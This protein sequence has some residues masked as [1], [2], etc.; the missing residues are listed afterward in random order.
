M[1]RRGGWAIPAFCRLSSDDL[2][3]AE[4][5]IELFER[6][7]GK[8]VGELEDSLRDFESQMES[9][10][11]HYKLVRGLVHILRATL[12]V[13]KPLTA[14]EPKRARRVVYEV[15]SRRGYALD[16]VQRDAIL[17]EAASKLG[18]SV[19]ELWKAYEAAYEEA[20]VVEGFD[21]PEPV[22]LLRRYNLSLAQTALF[23]AE[24]MEV[25]APFRGYEAK[26]LVRAVKVLG[27]MYTAVHKGSVL[28][29]R[30]DGPASLLKSTR[31]YGARF[32]KLLP[33]VTSLREWRIRALINRGGRKLFTSLHS[34]LRH[35]F[36]E[37]PP[38]EDVFDSYLEADFAR[39][40]SAIASGVELLREPE[41]IVLGGQVFIPDFAIDVGGKRVYLEIV[42]FW[43]DAYLRRKLEKLSK[44]KVP[45]VVAV[46][47]SL[48]CSDFKELPHQVVVFSGRLRSYDVLAALKKMVELPKP[49][50]VA[51]KSAVEAERYVHLVSK[52]GEQAS[53]AKA[54]AELGRAGLEEDQAMRVLEEL[55][56]EVVWKGIDPSKAIVRRKATSSSL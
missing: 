52:L 22:E 30:L 29:L 50:E 46:D 2:F 11:Y 25:E 27:L 17:K 12:K 6:H 18:L 36:P 43:T 13:S 51:P 33:F 49:K 47:R 56:Y 7:V 16:E 45:I 38:A 9:L 14:V 42:G 55:G 35:L 28:L 23:F 48:A 53:L 5:L 26:E 54:L 3:L 34:K 20:E 32:A 37:K 10:G 8:S 31:R 15:A 19:E 44:A 40:F 21:S 1:K 4:S 24:W 39:R 41:P